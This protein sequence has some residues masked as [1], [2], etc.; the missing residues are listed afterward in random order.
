[1]DSC[2][3]VSLKLASHNMSIIKDVYVI[4]QMGDDG[5][6]LLDEHWRRTW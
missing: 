5:R 6:Q 3:C 1:M 4:L 2:F